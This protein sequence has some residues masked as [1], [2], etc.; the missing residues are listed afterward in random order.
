[1]RSFIVPPALRMGMEDQRDGRTRAGR[2]A[3]APLKAPLGTGKNDVWHGT[4]D[5]GLRAGSAVAA[6][7]GRGLI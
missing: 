7:A 2:R 3:E 5:N 4:W 6:A 1:M